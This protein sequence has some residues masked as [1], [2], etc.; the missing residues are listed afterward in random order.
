MDT[1]GGK[2]RICLNCGGSTFIDS[3][4]TDRW[5]INLVRIW[6]VLLK[7]FHL[8]LRVVTIA[9]RHLYI[10]LRQS[11]LWYSNGATA[12]P[13]WYDSFNNVVLITAACFDI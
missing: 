3:T 12:L 6:G 2:L 1:I 10:N 13:A 9:M 11:L 8:I 5:F 7:N 4:I